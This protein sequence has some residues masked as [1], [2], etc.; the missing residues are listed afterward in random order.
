MGITFRVDHECRRIFASGEG[1][2]TYKEFCDYGDAVRP[3]HVAG[4]HELFDATAVVATLTPDQMRTLAVRVNLIHATEAH[5]GMTAIVARE[6]AIFGLS[7]MYATLTEGAGPE[8][9]VFY[10]LAEA[11]EWLGSRP[12]PRG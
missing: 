11:E 2:L 5:P 7:R 6:P 1:Q 10:T 3:H 9:G 4:Y 8:V 12:A